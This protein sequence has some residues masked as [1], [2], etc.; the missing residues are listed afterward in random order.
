MHLR[1]TLFALAALLTSLLIAQP[2]MASESCKLITD[3]P[4]MTKDGISIRTNV[5]VAFHQHGICDSALVK[6]DLY[7]DVKM[8][9]ASYTITEL[10]EDEQLVEAKLSDLLENNR[11]FTVAEIDIRYH[12]LPPGVCDELEAICSE[13]ELFAETYRIMDRKQQIEN[14][15]AHEQL[16]QQ[17]AEAIVNF[18]PSEPRSLEQAKEMI[19]DLRTENQD[20][21]EQVEYNRSVARVRVAVVLLIILFLVGFRICRGLKKDTDK[22][23][24]S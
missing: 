2:V 13:Q 10:I 23:L 20:L 14:E 18:D 22:I 1:N 4:S 5:M 12:S 3:I 9:A 7:E 11:R 16:V 19:H 24:D 8:M 17:Y 15:T 21:R 6:I